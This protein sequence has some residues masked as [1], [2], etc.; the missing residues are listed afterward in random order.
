[1]LTIKVPKAKEARMPART[2]PIAKK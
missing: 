1:V 2:V